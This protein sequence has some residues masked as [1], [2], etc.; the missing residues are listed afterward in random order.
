[1]K[2]LFG[3]DYVYCVGMIGIV[4]DKIVYGYVKGYERDNNL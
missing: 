4:V 3:E 1:M 2:V